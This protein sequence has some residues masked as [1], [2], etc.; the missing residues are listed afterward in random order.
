M[1][2]GLVLLKR[3]HFWGSLAGLKAAGLLRESPSSPRAAATSEPAQTSPTS[4][5]SS[6]WDEEHGGGF[7]RIQDTADLGT[8]SNVLIV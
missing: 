1:V 5:Q 7:E 4:P 6:A 8:L 2:P 3:W